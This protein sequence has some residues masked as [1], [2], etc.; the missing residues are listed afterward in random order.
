MI[1]DLLQILK[2][3]V[4]KIPNEMRYFKSTASDDV[5]RPRLSLLSS[6]GNDSESQDDSAESHSENDS[7]DS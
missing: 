7:S 3:E 2:D 6:V 4:D 1:L 5:T